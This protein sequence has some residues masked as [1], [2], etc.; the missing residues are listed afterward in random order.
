LPADIDFSIIDVKDDGVGI[1]EGNRTKLFTPFF[2]TK[3]ENGGT[4]L[5]LVISRSLLRA[6]GAD[7]ECIPAEKGACFRIFIP[8][9][10]HSMTKAA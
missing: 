9:I 5:G 6:F 10:I 2:T 1:S 7:V 3:R 8:F 4:D